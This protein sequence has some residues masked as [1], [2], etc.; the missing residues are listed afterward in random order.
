MSLL[1]LDF[2]FWDYL[3]GIDLYYHF[4]PDF[5]GVRFYYAPKKE[6]TAIREIFNWEKYQNRRFF[7]FSY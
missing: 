6:R 7:I 5:Y 3:R 2:F 4:T 1:K